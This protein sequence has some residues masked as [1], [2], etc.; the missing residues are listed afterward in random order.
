MSLKTM[1]T[2]HFETSHIY[3]YASFPLGGSSLYYF[4][5]KT[6][7][8]TNKKYQNKQTKNKANKQQQQKKHLQSSV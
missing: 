4:A 5:T 1:E 3:P 8:Q 2:S 6:N 7:K